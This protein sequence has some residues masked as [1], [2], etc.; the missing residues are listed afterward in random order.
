VTGDLAVSRSLDPEVRGVRP[1]LLLHQEGA[2]GVV[3]IVGLAWRDGLSLE[4]L[5]PVASTWMSVA[6]GLVGG[7]ASCLVLFSMRR[8]PPVRRLERFQHRLVR[9]W[10]LVDAVSVALFS[11]L[12]E[13]ALVRALLQ[14]VV[15]LLPAALL[16]SLL[17]VVPDRR[18]WMWPALALVLGVVLGALFELGG[19][20]AAAAAHVVIN[21]CALV[22]LR[23]LDDDP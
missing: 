17:H 15:G 4:G 7:V 14:P 21:L 13:E 8:L 22:R 16:F 12:A 23:S 19:Y 10:S 3:A 9:E 6:Y 1:A 20:P 2:L 11:G 18:L 5:S